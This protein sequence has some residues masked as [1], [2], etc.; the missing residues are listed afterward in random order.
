MLMRGAGDTSELDVL[1]PL[2]L[3]HAP[4]QVAELS[5]DSTKLE[6]TVRAFVARGHQAWPQLELTP[7]DF[8]AFVGTKLSTQIEDDLHGAL[9]AA[10]LYLVCGCLAGDPIATDEFEGHCFAEVSFILGRTDFHNRIGVDDLSQILRERLLVQRGLSSYAGRGDLRNWF[11]VATLRAAR[12]LLRKTAREVI[13]D[14]AVVAEF[15]AASSDPET[16]YLK[17]LYRDEVRSGFSAAMRGLSA[18]DRMILRMHYL[19]RVGLDAIAA[20]CDVHRVTVS[21][22]LATIRDELA[23]TIR[24]SLLTRL[25]TKRADLQSII[26]IQSQLDLS[27]RRHFAPPEHSGTEN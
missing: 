22:W 11:R 9:R 21:R 15:A 18:R 16:Q 17:E 7:S 27:L 25:G 8:V 14:D 12:N 19:D 1:V 10:D 20:V 3:A 13:V 26:L 6:P 24:R 23:K 5:V 4:A 2:L